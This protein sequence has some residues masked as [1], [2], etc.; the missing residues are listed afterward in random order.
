MK[1]KDC[2]SPLDLLEYAEDLEVKFEALQKENAALKHMSAY[3]REFSELLSRGF[4]A[5]IKE[6]SIAR[7]SDVTLT[8]VAKIVKETNDGAHRILQKEKSKNG[9]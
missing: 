6:T 7:P 3:H 9:K 2:E 4:D 1:A 8:A 5:I